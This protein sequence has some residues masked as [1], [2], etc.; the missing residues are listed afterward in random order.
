MQIHCVNDVDTEIAGLKVKAVLDQG[1][2]FTIVEFEKG[3]DLVEVIFESLPERGTIVCLLFESQVLILLHNNDARRLGCCC[4]GFPPF[5][6]TYAKNLDLKNSFPNLVKHV[7]AQRAGGFTIKEGVNTKAALITM[8]KMCKVI[9]RAI[10]I[11]NAT[12]PH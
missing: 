4:N 8:Q 2:T 11:H 10:K 1:I 3:D 12:P 7:K 5:K 6:R 9:E